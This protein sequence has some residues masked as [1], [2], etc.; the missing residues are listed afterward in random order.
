MHRSLMSFA[1]LLAAI[2]APIAT[3]AMAQDCGG[4]ALFED[5]FASLDPSWGE[6]K[7]LQVAGGKA[8]MS[9]EANAVWWVWNSA[10]A[11]P[12][13]ADVCVDVALQNGAADSK[14]PAAG[15]MFWVTDNA[16][17]YVF[18]VAPTGDYWI[19]RLLDGKWAM[20]PVATKQSA[21]V[22]QGAGKTNNLHVRFEGPTVTLFINGKEQSQQKLQPPSGP[23][24]VGLYAQAEEKSANRWD[25]SK[26]KVTEVK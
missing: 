14:I 21:D 19:S 18:M 1:F 3:Q 25:F 5:A 2:T 12:A 10:W 26:L 6:A 7:N 4:K 17:F 15:V 8:T 13:N 23:S 20:N 22:Q 16:N 11:F 9:V 24:Y